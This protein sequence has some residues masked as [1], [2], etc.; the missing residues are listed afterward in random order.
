[1]LDGRGGA[2]DV[3]APEDVAAEEGVLWVHMD[4]QDDGSRAWLAER[5]GLPDA[6]AEALLARESRPRS[7][8]T[9]DGVLVVLRGLNLNPGEDPE[10]MVSARVWID[11]ARILT[12]RRRRVM[13][14]QG[15][16]QSL[17]TANGPRTQGE[18]LA[19][20]VERMADLIGEFVDQQEAVLESA[21]AQLAG[22]KDFVA[23]RQNLA[24]L[25]RRI[26]SVRRFLMPQRDALDRLCRHTGSLIT[27]SETGALREEAD[28][29]TRY[30]EDLDL[31]RERAVVLQEE[32]LSQ[33]AQQQNTRVYVLSIVT[34]VF[35][36]L[37]F[38]TGLLGMNVGGL[39]GT[40]SAF[41]FLFA[42]VGMAVASAGLIAFFRWKRWI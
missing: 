15:V 22:V 29:I 36:P 33:I 1:V 41:G 16:Y 2:R 4:L 19:M 28:R 35:L 17:Q 20:L 31:A 40:D 6:M 21:E 23:F 5:S 25:R 30:L 32:F 14:V 42:V 26:A 37:G 39:P 34:A 11:R 7:I 27:D 18:F 3:A 13:S 24:D 38:V 10:D 9:D 12:T 8:V